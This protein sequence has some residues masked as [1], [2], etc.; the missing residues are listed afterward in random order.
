MKERPILFSTPM[1]RALLNTKPGIW[2]AEP[3]DP[4]MSYKSMTRRVVKRPICTDKNGCINIE[5]FWIIPERDS[6]NVFSYIAPHA[7]GDVLWV[8]ET[9]HVVA[10][11]SAGNTDMATIEY[12][13]GGCQTIDI[14][15]DRV[16]Y[17]AGKARWRPSIHMPREAARLFLEVKDVGVERVQNISER[18]ALAEGFP[19]IKCFYSTHDCPNIWDYCT[20]VPYSSELCFSGYWQHLN[21]K[22]GYPW[23]SNPWVWVIEFGRA[24]E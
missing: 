18:D 21:E 24:G 1:I 17:Y 3:I 13:A 14:T 19:Y 11:G 23:E 6:G 4:S 22:R 7:V 16:P 2:P 20:E 10:L 15:A 8:R 5:G 9:W 12:K